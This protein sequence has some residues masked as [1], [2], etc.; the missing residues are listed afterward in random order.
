MSAKEG[1]ERDGP[2]SGV[3]VEGIRGGW[4]TGLDGPQG[5]LEEEV[6]GPVW[7]ANSSARRR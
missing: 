4:T 5:T 6:E 3:E 2:L 7:G 1:P